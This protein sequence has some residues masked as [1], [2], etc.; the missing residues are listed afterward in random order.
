MNEPGLPMVE[1]TLYM[2]TLY[3]SKIRV[4]LQLRILFTNLAIHDPLETDLYDN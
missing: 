2:I 4:A 3:H 1:S